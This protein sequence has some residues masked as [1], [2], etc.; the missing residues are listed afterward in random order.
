MNFLLKLKWP[1][2]LLLILGIASCGKDDDGGGTG[3]TDLTASFQFEVNADNFM[4]V[5]FS[6][7]S[8]NATSYA[9]DFGDTN[10]STDES[11]T[12]TYAAEGTYTVTLTASDGTDSKTQSKDVTITDP[13]AQASILAGTGSKTWYLQ[14]EGVALGIGPAPGDDQFWSFGGVTPLGDRP[15][16]LDDNWTFNSD[17]T[18]TFE[19]NGTI[20]VDSEG[21]GGWLGAGVN[22]GCYDE[23][24]SLMSAAGDDLTAFENGGDYTYE[25]DPS[26]KSL[27]VNGLGFYIGLANKTETGDDFIPKSVKTYEV[28]NINSGD[29]ADTLHLSLNDGAGTNSWNFYLVSYKNAS[30]LPEIPGS[31]PT[32]GFSNVNDGLTV[33]FTNSSSSSTSYSWDFGDGNMSSD[34]NPVHTYA[35]EGTYTVTLTSM[36]DNG[37][38]DMTSQDIVVSTA[39]FTAAALS[40]AAGKI[41]KLDG[42]NSYFV[43]EGPGGN[44]YWGGVDAQ[45][46]MDRACQFDDEF[47]FSDDGTFEYDTKGDVWAEAYM[48]GPTACINDGDLSNPYDVFA[49]GTHTFTATDN[50]ITVNG[51][52]A[53][54]GFNKPF[55]GGELD[56]AGTTAPASTITYEVIDYSSAGNTEILTVSI[57]YGTANDYW[58]MRL[59]SEN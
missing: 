17:G 13:G 15:C 25:Y 36:D 44:N 33:T 53:F 14:R 58:T 30:D 6:N 52:G 11:P 1:L 56:N 9:W 46:V 48:L 43:G 45:G 7:F 27:V 29:V 21:N 8:S 37:Q 39:T 34:E 5:T 10:S 3:T 4:E 18:V 41:W 31:M 28:F 22:E 12:H 59:I 57:N 26:A 24:T 23:A 35:M 47:I 32:A 20:F 51:T 54:I 40:N 50:Q 38:S 55:N 49:S 42:A 2:C 19:S 16:I